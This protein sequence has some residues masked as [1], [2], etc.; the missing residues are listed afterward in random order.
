MEGREKVEVELKVEEEV[1][2]EVEERGVGPGGELFSCQGFLGFDDPVWSP[3]FVWFFL[4]TGAQAPSH[5]ASDRFWA[6]V[7]PPGLPGRWHRVQV[8]KNAT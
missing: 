7:S 2:V 4:E 8:K 5:P 6:G 3:V 1:K